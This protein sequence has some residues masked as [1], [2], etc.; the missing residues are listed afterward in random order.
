MASAPAALGPESNPMSGPPTGTWGPPCVCGPP[1]DLGAQGRL[2]C[3]AFGSLA[4]GRNQDS[5]V[6]ADSPSRTPSH[7]SVQVGLGLAVLSRALKTQCRSPTLPIRIKHW[8]PALA[9]PADLQW[10]S[11]LARGVLVQQ[12]GTPLPTR[13]AVDVR[14]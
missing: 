6:R 13:T 11:C 7:S 14:K 5:E 9:V 10:A 3:G 1:L 8:Q 12:V 4:L 2:G